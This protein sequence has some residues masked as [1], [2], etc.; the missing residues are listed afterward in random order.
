MELSNG[1]IVRISE[2]RCIGWMS[3]ETYITQYYGS[4]GRYEFSV[5]HHHQAVW[6]PLR[7]GQVV[8]K[9]VTERLQPKS[10]Y[11]MI[12]S[13]YD[14]AI[15]NIADTGGLTK[16][17]LYNRPKDCLMSLRVYLINTM[18]RT[19]FLSMI[20]AVRTKRVNFHLRISGRLQDIICQD[21]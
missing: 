11:D 14:K 20:F 17:H 19:I 10:I 18:E 4:E 7:P 3:P 1:G 8:M 13:D 2:N 5:A 16:P 9:D 12:N 6:D 21:L 15:Q